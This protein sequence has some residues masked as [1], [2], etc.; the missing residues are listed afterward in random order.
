MLPLARD[1]S[2]RYR[3]HTAIGRKQFVL[4]GP[5][6]PS[7]P[8]GSPWG[9]SWTPMGP[10]CKTMK[11]SHIRAADV[12]ERWYIFDASEFTLGRMASDIAMKL[13]GKDRPTYTPSEL[14]GAH[15][16]VINAEKAVV[17]GKKET[18]K[19]YQRY[20]GYPGGLYIRNLETLRERKPNDIVMLAV[21]RMLPKNRLGKNMLSRMKVYTGSEHPHTAQSPQKVETLLR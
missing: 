10:F 18:D 17:T 13:M 16:V 1:S 5:S 11:T 15:V 4:G 6:G 8:S 3:T 21:R 14:S 19:E 12:E 20:S 2:Q 9:P 7:G